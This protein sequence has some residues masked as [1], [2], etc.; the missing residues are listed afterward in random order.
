MIQYL[1]TKYGAQSAAMT[2]NVITYRPK[3][4]IREA[5]KAFGCSAEQVDRLA[6]ALGNLS[7]EEIRQNPKILAASVAACGLDP[8]S[9]GFL[10]C[11][12]SGSGCRICRGIWA[13][14]PAGW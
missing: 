7:T 12:R 13:S 6:G 4:A 3:S 11:S 14:T 2:A 5:A 10:K 1:Y 8:P 9:P